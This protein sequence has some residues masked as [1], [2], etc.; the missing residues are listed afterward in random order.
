ML[1]WRRSWT[2][3]LFLGTGVPTTTAIYSVP[4]VEMSHFPA[5]KNSTYCSLLMVVS[6]FPNMMSSNYSGLIERVNVSSN[7]SPAFFATCYLSAYFDILI[8]RRLY[9]PSSALFLVATTKIPFSL[10][11]ILE[12]QIEATPANG[13]DCFKSGGYSVPQ[14]GP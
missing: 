1:W 13:G 7:S 12:G 4:L 9:S 14:L 6:F 3:S 2:F 5:M 8:V 11:N 10:S